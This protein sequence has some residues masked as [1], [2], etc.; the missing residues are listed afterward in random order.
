MGVGFD[1]CDFGFRKISKNARIVILSGPFP[2]VF[3]VRPGVVLL[4]FGWSNSYEIKQFCS[5][6]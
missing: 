3:D 1:C 4:F 2:A 5:L 6:F